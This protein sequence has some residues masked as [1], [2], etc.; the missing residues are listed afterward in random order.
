[1]AAATT[2]T[3]EEMRKPFRARNARP[4]ERRDDDGYDYENETTE[5]KKSFTRIRH[6]KGCVFGASR[7]SV[8]AS[9]DDDD[10]A[11]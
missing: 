8:H 6:E 5:K 9:L 1:M 2:M 4:L 11:T 3:T 7:R 10:E